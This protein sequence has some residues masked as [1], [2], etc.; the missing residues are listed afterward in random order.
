[1]KIKRLDCPQFVK[2]LHSSYLKELPASEANGIIKLRT[3]LNA[4]RLSKVNLV[5]PKFHSD[6]W[7][8]VNGVVRYE[9]NKEAWVP[10][11]QKYAV[12]TFN[13]RL[14]ELLHGDINSLST[15]E[16]NAIQV[17]IKS[18]LA[19]NKQIK[20]FQ[21]DKYKRLIKKKLLKNRLK[22]ST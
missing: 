9:Y 8:L 11:D 16:S 2:K 12:R 15:D 21:R 14:D 19:S 5:R 1:M 10:I 3:D 17:L 18:G 13:V 20:L 6:G 4:S 7:Y 22:Q